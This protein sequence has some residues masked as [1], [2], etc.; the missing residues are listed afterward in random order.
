M[1]L[2]WFALVVWEAYLWQSS[3]KTS[4]WAMKSQSKYLSFI[5][6]SSLIALSIVW[7][8]YLPVIWWWVDYFY[9]A[10]ES[11]FT[12]V[13]AWWADTSSFFYWDVISI[14]SWPWEVWSLSKN[15]LY[16]VLFTIFVTYFI[17]FKWTKSIWKAVWVTAL[18]PFVTL[19]ILA[20]KWLTLPWWIDG[21]RFLLQTDLSKLLEI[22]TW[23]AAI[24]QIVLSVW[25]WLSAYTAYTSYKP[26]WEEVVSTSIFV[27]IWNTLISVLSAL[28]VFSSLGYM[29]NLSWKTISEITNWG[30]GLIFEAFPAIFNSFSVTT[31]NIFA[32]IFFITVFLLAIDSFMGLVDTI[33]LT[34]KEKLPKI[35]W[36]Y[37]SALIL[38]LVLIWSLV[39][40]MWN[41]LYTLDIVDRYLTNAIM[42][43]LAFIMSILALSNYK[44]VVPYLLERS[45]APKW[46]V[47]K[48]TIIWAWIV[49][50][51]L[52]WYIM[53]SNFLWD[54]M[55]YG[56]YDRE[57]IMIWIYT[58]I[59][60]WGLWI[61]FN[62]LEI[63]FKKKTK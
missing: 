24:S 52:V 51:F 46:F 9:Y 47:N 15:A 2:V 11:L 3:W 38:V 44:K 42:T 49:S 16:W 29:A 37:I 39:F 53:I 12:W 60:V 32:T 62:I 8:Y 4:A 6:Y 30:P 22:S 34:V 1:I 36:N 54:F 14:T 55:S 21:I 45:S 31:W 19:A 7:A 50:F 20:I 5:W 25:V 10:L 33:S 17:V 40:M 43:V 35:K 58:I 61:I 41:G 23:V 57:Y 13:F 59:A 63:V 28:V 27:V 26:E 18:V 48:Y 56:G